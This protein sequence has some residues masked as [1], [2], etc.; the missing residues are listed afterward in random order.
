MKCKYKK[1]LK[2]AYINYDEDYCSNA[3]LRS[4]RPPQSEILA[5]ATF[6]VTLSPG[7]GYYWTTFYTSMANYQA[8][9]GVIVYKEHLEGRSITHSTVD[10][11][12]INKGQ[13]V[14]LRSSTSSITLTKTYSKSSDDY[15]DNSL[16]GTDYQITNPGHAYALSYRDSHGVAFYKLSSTGRIRANKAYLIIEDVY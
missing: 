5:P 6:E 15:S 12:I 1:F 4:S 10:D 9:E 16:I 2:A 11:R 7:E 3:V 8:P 13:G 14:V